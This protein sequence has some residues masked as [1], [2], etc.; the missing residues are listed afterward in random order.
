MNLKRLSGF[1]PNCYKNINF[2]RVHKNP[3]NVFIY[4][5]LF[6]KTRSKVT[7]IHYKIWLFRA[8]YYYCLKILLLQEK[9]NWSN[10][11]KLLKFFIK[12]L[13]D[14]VQYLE[15]KAICSIEDV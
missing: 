15:V 8:T 12:K 10:F 13:N 6:R 5:L 3:G 2:R 1:I 4:R 7:I 9:T 11:I 14:L